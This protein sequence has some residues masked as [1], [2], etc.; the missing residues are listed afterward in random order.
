MTAAIV[1]RGN[2]AAGR[3]VPRAASQA[4]VAMLTRF[5]TPCFRRPVREQLVPASR[6]VQSVCCIFCTRAA[7]PPGSPRAKPKLVA[8]SVDANNWQARLSASSG[9]PSAWL[10]KYRAITLAFPVLSRMA[11][12]KAMVEPESGGPSDA[13]SVPALPEFSSSRWVIKAIPI[14]AL[15]GEPAQLVTMPGT[16]LHKISWAPQ[17]MQTARRILHAF[18]ARTSVSVET[19]NADSSARRQLSGPVRSSA[20]AV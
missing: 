6:L 11:S 2:R 14:S 19:A 8:S 5:G 18:T 1:T 16:S 7:R 15:I 3:V 13:L 17:I 9:L 10:R 4:G 20:S 12:A